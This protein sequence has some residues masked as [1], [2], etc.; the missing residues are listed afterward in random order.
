MS[1]YKG[2]NQLKS[3]FSN[4]L[5]TARSY[6]GTDVGSTIARNIFRASKSIH[7]SQI[8]KRKKEE[9]LIMN[10]FNKVFRFMGGTPKPRN[11]IND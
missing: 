5:P 10:Q 1:K 2:V 11:K 3:L 4:K 6:P 8:R 7:D 9:E